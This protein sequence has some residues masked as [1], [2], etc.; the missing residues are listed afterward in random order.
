MILN[1]L[2]YLLNGDTEERLKKE[3]FYVEHCRSRVSLIKEKAC[4]LLSKEFPLK[5]LFRVLLR[6]QR[7]KLSCQSINQLQE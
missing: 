6:S 4:A 5:K 3:L 2:I 7:R 1:W